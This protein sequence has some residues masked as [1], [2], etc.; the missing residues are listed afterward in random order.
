VC[1]YYLPEIKHVIEGQTS[2]QSMIMRK[3]KQGV[4]HVY[5]TGAADVIAPCHV[6]A[7][8]V[9]TSTVHLVRVNAPNVTEVSAE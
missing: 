4:T 9:T 8:F 5:S 3:E 6:T 1:N 7:A 2:T